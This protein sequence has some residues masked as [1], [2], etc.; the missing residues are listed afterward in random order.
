[1]QTFLLIA[2]LTIFSYVTW[3][4]LYKMVRLLRRIKKTLMSIE[5]L[6]KSP[7]MATALEFYTIIDGRLTKVEK[8]YPLKVTQNLPLILKPVDAKGNPALVDTTNGVPTWGISDVSFAELEVAADGMSALLKP[9]GPLGQFQVLV[10]ADADLG[11]GVKE[12]LGAMDVETIAGE[13]VSVVIAAGV[14]VDA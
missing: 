14:P 9:K 4:L 8:M 6:L 12:I 3:G 13:A 2:I 10:T 1:M 7:E 5:S 11:A